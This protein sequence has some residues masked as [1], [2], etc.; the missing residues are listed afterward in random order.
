[1]NDPNATPRQVLDLRDY[2][3]SRF[4]GAVTL[5][6]GECDFE[7][8]VDNVRAGDDMAIWLRTKF[9]P[10]TSLDSALRAAMPHLPA[11]PMVLDLKTLTTDRPRW[12]K[13]RIA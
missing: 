1:M 8:V 3:N 6:Y 4:V 12:W 13:A 11:G 7:P 9:G 10:D 5:E 2:V